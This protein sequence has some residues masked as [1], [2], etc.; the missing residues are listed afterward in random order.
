[1]TPKH[2]TRPTYRTQ[3]LAI[4]GVLLLLVGAMTPI[5]LAQEDGVT[6]A[7]SPANPTIANGESVTFDVVVEG[8]DTVGAI[9]GDVA[10]TNPS[11]AEI[12]AVSLGGSPALESARVAA[13]GDSAA[14]EA[15]YGN[16]PL[17]GSSVVVAT[18]TVVGTADGQT[19]IDLFD[20]AAGD[21]AGASLAVTS[22]SDSSLT[23]GSSTDQPTEEPPAT[24]DEPPVTTD[25]PTEQPPATTDEPPATTEEPPATTEQPP[26]TTE[27]PPTTTE[28][29]PTTTEEPPTTTEEPPATTDEPPA[30]TEEPPSTT[31]EPTEEPTEQPTEQPTETPD[32]GTDGDDGDDGESTYF[33]VDFVVGEPKSHVGPDDGF[34]SDE[35]RLVRYA[36]GVD[37][38]TTR[39]GS[40][41]T[42]ADDAAA[43]LDAG[44]V[45]VEDGT[46]TISFAV[47][48]GCELTLSLVSYE[49]PGAGFDRGVSQEMV[50][51]S[52]GTFGPGEYSLTVELPDGDEVDASAP[53]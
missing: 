45:Q 11:V 8:A 13:D 31:E 3:T 2:R 12:T 16:D 30:T 43:C 21:A 33:Q 19:G 53:A 36:H 1:M 23:V 32:D 52:T 25:E 35:Q 9:E 20:V 48:D 15:I 10:L 50:D 24:T 7:A 49:K 26:A 41:P 40:T 6:V 5:A 4:L 39:S 29:P 34:Y 44:Y 28:Q 14:F 17:T 42:L 37:D 46:A 18:V 51:A 27:Q 47:D 38:R 22:V